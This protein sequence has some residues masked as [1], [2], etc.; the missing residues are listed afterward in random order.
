MSK[1]IH[2]DF[3]VAV[4]CEFKK[5]RIDQGLSESQIADKLLLSTSQIRGI[6]H[7]QQ[8]LF[9]NEKLFIQSA[10][11]YASLLG[12]SEVLS[13]L[14]NSSRLLNQTSA[15]ENILPIENAERFSKN[16]KSKLGK[17]FK[18][19]YLYWVVTFLSISIIVFVGWFQNPL[20][21]I[22]KKYFFIPN[23]QEIPESSR[24]IPQKPSSDEIESKPHQPLVNSVT[25]E[26]K[27]SP[28]I[29]ADKGLPETSSKSECLLCM[30]FSA[31]TWVQVT[32]VDGHRLQRTFQANESIDLSK[33]LPSITSITTGNK[34]ATQIILNNHSLDLSPF[35]GTNHLIAKIRRQDLISH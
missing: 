19:R 21:N 32:F 28:E 33:D 23:R 24:A 31:P 30:N 1:Q 18:Y 8:S 15:I 22:I 2:S 14:E 5:A 6:E 29:S 35:V 4:G 17:S 13:E 7:G 12:L 20:E 9:Y 34:P 10:T 27:S 26:V 16:Y 11:K 3:Y 25:S